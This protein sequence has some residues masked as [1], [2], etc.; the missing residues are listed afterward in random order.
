MPTIR[1]CKK[2]RL[3]KLLRKFGDLF[4]STL[5]TWKTAPLELGLKHDAKPVFLQPYPVLRVH[6]MIFRKE[7][8]RLVKLGVLEY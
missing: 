2:E 5:G 1:K 6:K 7:F 8:K 4:S 3:L